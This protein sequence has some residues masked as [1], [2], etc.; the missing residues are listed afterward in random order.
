[1]KRSE[2]WQAVDAVY[3]PSLGRSLVVDLYLPACSG[4]AQEALDRGLEPDAVWAALIE[5]T[6][7]SE[8]ARWVHRIDPKRRRR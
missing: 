8:E 2:F 3:G 7:Q 4:T 5:E 1:M 6:G